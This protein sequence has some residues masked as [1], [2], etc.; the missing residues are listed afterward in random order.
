L[1]EQGAP[2]LQIPPAQQIA[3]D[4]PHA[5]HRLVALLHA[6]PVLHQKPLPAPGQQGSPSPPQPVHTLAAHAEK[7]AVQSTPPGQHGWPMPPH[8]PLPH[9]PFEHE[10]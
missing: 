3:P 8:V 5:V 2:P 9:E 7:G 1:P 4:E 10:P 6:S